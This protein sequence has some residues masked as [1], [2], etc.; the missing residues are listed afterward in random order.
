ML[1]R[2]NQVFAILKHEGPPGLLNRLWTRKDNAL[3]TTRASSP[4]QHFSLWGRGPLLAATRS[5][6][7]QHDLLAEDSAARILINPDPALLRAGGVAALMLDADHL[8]PA[9]APSRALITAIRSGCT[10][11]VTS[12][13][14]LWAV[15]DLGGLRRNIIRVD[16]GQ[17]EAETRRALERWLVY[18]GLMAPA[19]YLQN[20]TD[21]MPP[22]PDRARLCLS[23]PEYPE[24]RAAFQKDHPDAGFQIIE[25]MRLLPAWK[26]C[27]WSY[28][29]IA[30]RALQSGV[31]R[32]TI[33]EDDALLAPSFAAHF[34]DLNRYLDGCD[35]DLFNGI[36]TRISDPARMEARHRLGDLTLLHGPQMMG[37]VFNIYNRRALERLAD[38]QPDHGDAHCNTIDEWLN[39]MAG[40]RVVT[41]VPFLAGHRRD[42]RSTIFGFQNLRYS[43]MIA[44]TERQLTRRAR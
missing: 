32:L 29:A 19:R 41:A 16:A 6:L 18:Q 17:P 12:E 34:A 37:M 33:C 7:A 23:L 38:W 39:R 24:R 20:M 22:L 42:Q 30:T 4:P 27:A 25:G 11:I 43:R 5:A 21:A 28:K 14:A 9:R 36:M 1:R 40:L 10:L 26:G 15:Q 3:M 8:P 44:A 31:E 2:A 13:A 35:W